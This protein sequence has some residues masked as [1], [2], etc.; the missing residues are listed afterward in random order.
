MKTRTLTKLA[1]AGLI[2]AF[3]TGALANQWFGD[4]PY[5]KS[6]AAVVGKTTVAA[7]KTQTVS[8]IPAAPSD[9]YHEQDAH[10]N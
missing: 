10:N 6:Q 5:W 8:R 1:T 3:S 9:R 7:K 2:T 4:D